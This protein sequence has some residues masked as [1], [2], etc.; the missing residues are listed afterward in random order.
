MKVLLLAV[1]MAF[2]LLRADESSWSLEKMI[3]MATGKEAAHAYGQYGCH[4]GW[5]GKGSPVDATDKCCVALNCCYHNL[6]RAGCNPRSTTYNIDYKWNHISCVK[7]NFCS[8]KVCECDKAVA[9]CLAR[10]KKTFKK[11]YEK[12]DHNNCKGVNPRC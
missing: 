2:G 11:K 9:K 1:I 12:Y 5:E 3:T 8:N 10:N 4:C 7:A 6:E